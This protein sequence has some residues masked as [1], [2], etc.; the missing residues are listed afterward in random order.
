MSK[1]Q[2]ALKELGECLLLEGA[3]DIINQER[4][5]FI[6][7]ELSV[8]AIVK[9]YHIT[10]AFFAFNES[11]QAYIENMSFYLED[12]PLMSEEEYNL[13]KEILNEA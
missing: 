6:A 11:Y 8:L 1:G 4:I 12:E 7:K 2:E 10:P 3:L 5:G 9:K 13:A